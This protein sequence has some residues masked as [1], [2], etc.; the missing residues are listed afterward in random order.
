M[1]LDDTAT[2]QT[3][4]CT[5][6]AA[7]ETEGEPSPT[8]RASDCVVK[9]RCGIASARGPQEG[10]KMHHCRWGWLGWGWGVWGCLQ[11]SP[12]GATIQSW[13]Q[14]KAL[15]HPGPAVFNLANE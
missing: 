3:E 1:S 9:W 12:T 4:K 5:G 14:R 2:S 13:V 6:S 11:L 8:G 7:G 10:W 15:K